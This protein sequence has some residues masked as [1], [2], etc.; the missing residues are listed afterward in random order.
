MNPDLDRLRPYPFE[1][2]ATLLAS[3]DPP[4]DRPLLRL[5]VGEPQHP[6]PVFVI[7]VFREHLDLLARYPATRGDAD[8]R[9]RPLADAKGLAQGHRVDLTVR[10]HGLQRREV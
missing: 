10:A 3:V 5:S 2:L 6:P 7:E 4:P 9:V 1:R 8:L